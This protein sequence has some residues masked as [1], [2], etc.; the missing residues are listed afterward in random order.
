LLLSESDGRF[1]LRPPP[2]ARSTPNFA[3][4]NSQ[5]DQLPNANAQ[6]PTA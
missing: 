2:A 6:R 1:N 4:S 3:T 5:I